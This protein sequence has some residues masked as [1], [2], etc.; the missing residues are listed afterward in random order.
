MA[1]TQ[2]RP[3]HI[4][5]PWPRAELDPETARRY[6]AAQMAHTTNSI[7]RQR[8]RE[9]VDFASRW[10]W[11]FLLVVAVGFGLALLFRW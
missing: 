3:E 11:P 9:D 6:R 4:E 5:I 8:M 7:E 10:F 1:T 2:H